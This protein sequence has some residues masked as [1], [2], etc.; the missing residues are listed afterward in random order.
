M[1]SNIKLSQI[2]FA[3]ILTFV[4]VFGFSSSALADGPYQPNYGDPITVDGDISDWDLAIDHF[5]VLY[6]EDSDIPEADLYLRFSDGVLYI[7]VR[8]QN[9]QNVNTT[10]G[11]F[12]M[13]DQLNQRDVDHNDAPP[14]GILPDLAWVNLSGSLSE[15]WEAAIL[16][17]DAI[18]PNTTAHNIYVS[19][20]L[21]DGT[22]KGIIA[23]GYFPIDVYRWDY[24][25]LPDSYGTYEL[26]SGPKHSAGVLRLGL[27]V[28]GESD[29]QPDTNPILDDINGRNDED[30]VLAIGNWRLGTPTFQFTVNGCSDT[31]FFN[32]WVDWG[33]DGSFNAGDILFTNR[34]V[35]TGTDTYSFQLPEGVEFPSTFNLRFR[36]CDVE[37]ACSTPHS[38]SSEDAPFGEVEDYQ[39]SFDPNVLTLN[40]FTA[41]PSQNSFIFYLLAGSIAVIIL[42]STM[43]IIQKRKNL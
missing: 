5:S 4:I 17:E 43:T 39:W 13:V 12:V 2:I 37:D 20:L 27:Q 34:S 18:D 15:G 26:S 16:W 29:G 41:T 31:C 6:R 30:G 23:V 8:S 22:Q 21:N 3:T 9:G 42:L 25:D 36:L 11:Q 38:L 14:D 10:N 24:G 33:N 19:S 40:S 28:D 32:A 7:L 1:K 35:T